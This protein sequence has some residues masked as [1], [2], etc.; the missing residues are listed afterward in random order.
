MRGIYIFP[1]GKCMCTFPLNTNFR[2]GKLISS[3]FEKGTEKFTPTIFP[4]YYIRS[5]YDIMWLFD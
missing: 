5:T 2:V 3:K 1:S 4:E